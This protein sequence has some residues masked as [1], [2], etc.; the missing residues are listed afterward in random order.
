MS[1]QVSQLELNNDVSLNLHS[2]VLTYS[3][4]N[5]PGLRSVIHLQGCSLGCK[6]CFNPNTHDFDSGY[7][8]TIREV[9]NVI[10]RDVEGVTISGGEP[11]QQPEGLLA[12]VKALRVRG[13]SIIVFSGY[14]KAELNKLPLGPEILKCV[15]I[16][17]DGRYVYQKPATEGLRGSSNQVIHFLSD[18]YSNTVLL[19]RQTEISILNNGKVLITGFPN[20][21]LK[22]VFL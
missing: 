2:E 7:I 22:N 16:L 9:C 5:E 21:K 10:P 17:V 19:E 20:E 1:E 3:L 12:L 4:V 6:G 8:K 11:F 15:D 13:Y 14:T 18:R